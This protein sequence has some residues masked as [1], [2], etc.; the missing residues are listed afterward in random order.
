VDIRKKIDNNKEVIGVVGLGYVGLPLAVAF[1]EAELHVIGFDK[2]QEYVD[3]INQ[4]ENY[5]KDIRDAALKE[6]ISNEF[7]K[8]TTDFS[9]INYCDVLLICVPTETVK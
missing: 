9:K 8:A 5:I 4:G 2:S 1:A 7:L 6:A 3:K